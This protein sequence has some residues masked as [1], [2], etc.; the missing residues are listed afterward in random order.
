MTQ[1]PEHFSAGSS[2]SI[3]DE[4]IRRCLLGYAHA[5]EQAKFEELL[6]LDDEM[7]KRVRLAEFELADDFSF[8]RLSADERELFTSNFLV[9]KE[10]GQ[11]LAASLALRK[12]LS[13]RT[14]ETNAIETQSRQSI[15]GWR[16]TNSSLFRYDNPVFSF[17]LALV[18]LVLFGGLF[19]L[20]IKSPHVQPPEVVKHP[21]APS[22]GRESHHPGGPQSPPQTPDSVITPAESAPVATLMLGP[23]PQS[24]DR[25][26]VHFTTP[27]MEIDFV[28]LE[29]LLE[30]SEAATYQAELLTSEGQQIAVASKLTS[31]NANQQMKL[32][33]DVQATLLRAANYQVILRLVNGE[34]A[35]EVGRYNF[36]VM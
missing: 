11:S 17:G 19:W 7:E 35:Q 6:L 15:A 29:F 10:R 24:D 20:L 5:D 14:A 2:D 22:P 21:T 8:G 9:T 34:Q 28:R 13:R 23:D 32:V 3:S 31:V 1:D 33:W 16:L 4:T 12:A 30:A 18:A 36:T 26:S 27:P 25:H